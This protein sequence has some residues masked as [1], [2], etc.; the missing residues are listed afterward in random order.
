MGLFGNN[1][2]ERRRKENLRLMED[3]R[4]R[5]AREMRDISFDRALYIQREGGLIGF[6]QSGADVYLIV[7]PNL[8][9]DE[10]FEAVKLANCRARLE[11][12]YVKSEGMGGMLGM[13]KKGGQG[14]TLHLEADGRAEEITYLSGHNFMMAVEPGA[15]NP[16]F[17]EKRRRGDANLVW[18]MRSAPYDE[19]TEIMRRWLEILNR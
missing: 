4:L 9:A 15:K 14:Y 16:L 13:G 10:P 12:V 2:A 19:C 1:E 5:F 7:G 17:D 11:D 18:D 3:K 6:A 8:G